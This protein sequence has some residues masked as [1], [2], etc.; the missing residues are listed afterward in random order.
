VKYA[1]VRA[2]A[3]WLRRGFFA[4]VSLGLAPFAVGADA[5]LRSQSSHVMRVDE[6]WFVIED[7]HVEIAVF[8]AADT[9]NRRRLCARGR[10]SEDC[11]FELF[12]L[13]ALERGAG[14]GSRLMRP[15]I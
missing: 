9:E 14:F 5:G 10:T 12:G 11:H 3:F 15:G 13:C 1:D 4:F 6:D 2:F 8:F 7:D